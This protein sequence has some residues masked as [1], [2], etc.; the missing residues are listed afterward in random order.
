[1]DYNTQ[2]DALIEQMGDAWDCG[3]GNRVAAIFRQLEELA[4]ASCRAL[5][6]KPST[7]TTAAGWQALADEQAAMEAAAKAGHLSEW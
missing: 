5:A 7:R 4:G 2:R 1:M 6:P 3:D